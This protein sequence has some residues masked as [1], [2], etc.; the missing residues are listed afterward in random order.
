[1]T[2]RTASE[3][4]PPPPP[5]PPR[6]VTA[7]ARRRAWADPHVRFWWLTG[8]V[9]VGAGA[10]LLAS[11]YF[12][13]RQDARLVESGTPVEAT[14]LQADESVA[15][16][17]TLPGDKPVRLSYEVGERKFEVS[18]PYLQGRP[19]EQ[20]IEVGKTVPIRIDPQD[21][22]RW[23]AR[24]RPAPLGPEL[25]GGAITVSV[26]ALILLL[27]AAFRTRVVRAW[28]KGDAVQAV[29]L[30]ARHTALAP[31]AWAVRCTPAE[32]GD[33]RVLE[34]FLPVGSEV[35]QGTLF[36]VLAPTGGRV[37]AARWFE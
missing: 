35:G 13:W 14:V 37:V 9:L 28:R 6:E 4:P 20:Y 32:A 23:T 10:Y 29:V 17:K 18:A 22:T 24:Q 7:R 31:R 21:P 33:D 19:A 30:S 16:G 12:A 11:R 5:A 26:G 2:D 15:R 25:I 8:L 34:V 1:M 3:A 27:G 36:W